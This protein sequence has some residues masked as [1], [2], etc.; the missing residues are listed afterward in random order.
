MELKINFSCNQLLQFG[1][2]FA[3]QTVESCGKKD[4]MQS[5]E[6]PVSS[7]MCM[8]VAIGLRK[9]LYIGFK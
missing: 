1:I 8:A 9:T 4:R 7:R 5:Y 6:Y 2:M 3:S